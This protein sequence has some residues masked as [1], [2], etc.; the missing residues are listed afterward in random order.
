MLR[1]QTSEIS[2]PTAAAGD[3]QRMGRGTGRNDAAV[4]KPLLGPGVYHE[5]WMR[6]F[7]A[8]RAEGRSPALAR[9]HAKLAV[10][11]ALDA[12]PGARP[13]RADL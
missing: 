12:L 8:A 2:A 7:E 4:P 6:A 1:T 11:K 10:G 5:T 9:Y 13:R 3:G